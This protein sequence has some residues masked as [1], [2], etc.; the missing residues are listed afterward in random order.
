MLIFIE[1]LIKQK[2]EVAKLPDVSH[3]IEFK[4]KRLVKNTEEMIASE[5]GKYYLEF[6]KQL[7]EIG[8]P[9]QVVSA[10]L[11]EGYN[12]EFDEEHYTNVKE[13]VH[14]NAASA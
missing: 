6:A 10:L 8:S 13:D 3:V 11:K 9:E 4:K 7:L 5:E 2:I 1:R 12:T 14:S